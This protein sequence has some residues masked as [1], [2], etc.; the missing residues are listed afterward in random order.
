MSALATMFGGRRDRRQLVITVFCG[1]LFLAWCGLVIYHGRAQHGHVLGDWLLDYRQGFIRRGLM[2]ALLSG[3]ADL[4]HLPVILWVCLAQMAQ[5]AAFLL[6][7]LG[8]LAG[9]F[10]PFWYVLLLLSPATLLFSFF[11]VSGVGRKETLYFALLAW[12]VWGLDRQRVTAGLT[13]V[14]TVASV[15]ITLSHELILFYA[16]YYLIAALGVPKAQRQQALRA[17]WCMLLGAWA[18]GAAVVLFARPLDGPAY[19]DSLMQSGLSS[20]VCQGIVLWKLQDLRA[21]LDETLLTIRYFGYV[22]TYALAL[23]LSL[24]PVFFWLRRYR[25]GKVRR[26]LRWMLVAWACSSLAFLLAVDWGRFIQIHMVSALTVLALRLRRRDTLA[27]LTASVPRFN[28]PSARVRWALAVLCLLS[29]LVWHMPTCCEADIGGGVAGKAE[30]GV[31][32][33]M[34][35]AGL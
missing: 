34:R 27:P 33:L 23:F 9:R 31:A 5:F 6:L 2:G 17:A 10:K 11:E 29:P 35:L 30:R 16:P 28:V 26:H 15:A 22:K 24:M 1:V 3:L 7:L 25:P 13:L 18:A 14:W 4:T 8:V 12:F 21:S 19:C 32:A 20:S